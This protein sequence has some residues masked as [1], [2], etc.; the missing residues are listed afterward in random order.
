[1]AFIDLDRT[2]RPV[3]ADDLGD[4]EVMAALDDSSLLKGDSWTVV[5][6]YLRVVLLAEA[7]S[8]KTM[9]M[10]AQAR[11]LSGTGKCAVFIPIEEL[12]DQDI[13]AVLEPAD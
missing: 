13:D 4:P 8:G 9:E 12:A 10:K 6:E 7:G 1:M 5:L 11:R 2:F 3:A